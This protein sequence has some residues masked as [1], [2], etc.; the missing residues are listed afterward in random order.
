MQGEIPGLSINIY[1]KQRSKHSLPRFVRF[2]WRKQRPSFPSSWHVLERQTPSATFWCNVCLHFA[3]VRAAG[4]VYFI[5]V[6]IYQA[7][8]C[9]GRKTRPLCRWN[10]SGR[11]NVRASA[12][13]G[14]LSVL[15]TRCVRTMLRLWM[16]II[17]DS[18]GWKWLKTLR[19]SFFYLSS[20]IQCLL[21]MYTC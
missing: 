5:Y 8:V 6:Q 9:L 12:V 17:D 21:F 11:I 18:E 15:H 16:L 2:Q 7:E 13:L 4:Q 3:P 14:V 1:K 19:H 20:T 10:V